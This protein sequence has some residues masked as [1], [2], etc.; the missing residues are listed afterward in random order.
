MTRLH[1]NSIVRLGTSDKVSIALFFAVQSFALIGIGIGM[2]T[3]IAILE[4][5]VQTLSATT[6]EIR[7]EFREFKIA[8]KSN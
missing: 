6:N 4:E 7:A 1:D 2:W 5:R 8:A 3:R